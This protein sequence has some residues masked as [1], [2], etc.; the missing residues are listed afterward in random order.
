VRRQAAEALAKIGNAQAVEGLIAALNHSDSGVRW[1]AAVALGNIGNA[2]AVEG[3]IAALNDSDSGVRRQAAVALGNIGNAETLKNLIEFWE[4]DIYRQ[5]I[6]PLARTL[7]VR[8]SKEKQPF[9]PVYPKFVRFK[10]SP[11]LATV[12]ATVKR[13]RHLLGQ[14]IREMRSTE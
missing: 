3:L 7:A 2:Q 6:F 9:I 14:K 10:Y 1:E 12:L 11:I 13:Y 5:D 4:I 8:F